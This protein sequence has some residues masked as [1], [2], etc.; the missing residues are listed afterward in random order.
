MHR[1]L[2]HARTS[3]IRQAASHGDRPRARRTPALAALTA[4]AALTLTT[5]PA[6]AAASPHMSDPG[7]SRPGSSAA[8]S[9]SAAAGIAVVRP[10]ATERDW[11]PLSP[12]KWEFSGGEVI[13]VERGDEPEGPRRPFEYAIVDKGPELES[14]RYTA[15]VRIDEP[16][17]RDDRDVILVFNYRSPTQ[18]Y[19]VHLSQDNT[20]YAHN[21][22]FKVDDA[23]RERLDDQ[24]DGEAGAPPAIDDLDWHDVRL[25]YHAPSGRIAVYVDGGRPLMTATDATF[26]GGRIGFGSF[27]NYGRIKD[28]TAIGTRARTGH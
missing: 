27:D 16:V 4:V 2:P 1:T 15:S 5:W 13:Q 19:Y 22:I 3:D 26:S 9:G 11:S 8:A 18:Y 7:P 21:G 14:L 28:V 25:D 12:E 6:A 24:W 23:D 20:I 10:H 17:E